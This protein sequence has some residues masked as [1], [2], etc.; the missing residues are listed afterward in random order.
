MVI[1]N[2]SGK[3]YL[4]SVII[5]T[6]ILNDL[7][8]P[9]H[10]YDTNQN[11]RSSLDFV[12]LIE[13]REISEVGYDIIQRILSV[14]NTYDPT[15]LRFLSLR[16][17]KILNQ[18]IAFLPKAKFRNPYNMKELWDGIKEFS[19]RHEIDLVPAFNN[20]FPDVRNINTIS[21]IEAHL[22]YTNMRF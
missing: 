6:A 4:T 9:D 3:S 14:Q 13:G 16:C 21:D 11:M 22:G 10:I 20:I 19:E 17:P 1:V 8:L 15:M 18:L 2:N 5:A 7:S 12:Y